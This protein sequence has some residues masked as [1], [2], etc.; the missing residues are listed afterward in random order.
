MT[1]YN[2]IFEAISAGDAN[3]IRALVDS[4]HDPKKSQRGVSAALFAAKERQAKCLDYVIE[5]GCDGSLGDYSGW[6]PAL[7]AMRLGEEEIL[8][9]IEDY[10]IDITKA[11][12]KGDTLAHAAAM[13]SGR[14]RENAAS[15]LRRFVSE[16]GISLSERNAS[17][18][19]ASEVAARRGNE[20][21]SKE[22]SNLETEDKASVAL[23]KG[24]VEGS[25]QREENDVLPIIGTHD[26][27]RMRP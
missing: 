4:G 12:K 9:T 14:D 18:L 25:P 15:M 2:N 3:A 8:T 16:K 5:E 17:G 23:K 6:T 22:I 24:Q 26:R 13:S 1:P 21:V 19:T 27:R 20:V 11:S 7:V 10:G